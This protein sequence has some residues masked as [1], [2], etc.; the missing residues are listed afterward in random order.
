MFSRILITADVLRPFPRESEWESATWKNARWLRHML[1]PA[2]RQCGHEPE[3]LSWDERLQPGRETWFDTPMLY[4]RLGRELTLESWATLARSTTAPQALIDA[5]EA[6]CRDALV[7]GYEMPEVMIDALT[8]LNRP[9]VDVILHPWRFLPDL[10]F[11]LRT[12][13]PAF[14]QVI[15]AQRLPERAATTQAERIQAKAA[16]MKPVAP[17]PPGT[18]LVVGQVSSDRAMVGADG[19]FVSLEQHLPR[20]HELCCEHPL[21]LYRA[22][23]YAGDQ[24][25]SA[26]AVARLPAIRPTSE[27]FYQLLSQPEL[28]GVVALNSSCLVE[29]RAFGRWGENLVPYLYDFD[30]DQPARDGAPGSPVP[31]SGGWIEP[32]FWQALLKGEGAGSGV[33]ADP[34]PN[35][36]RRSMNADWGYGFIEQV[37]A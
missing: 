16:W 1:A 12:N 7:V 10:V 9:F 6:P 17:M 30:A 23:P 8:R 24:D 21:V 13:V 22:H 31:L 19:G 25:P 37:C 35:V 4:R 27:N 14:D 20:L 33:F 2:L 28:E 26:R 32:C 15:R 36:L 11:A 29:A 5:L 3:L 18:V 34:G